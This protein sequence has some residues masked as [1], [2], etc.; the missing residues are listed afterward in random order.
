MSIIAFLLMALP[1]QTITFPPVGGGTNVEVVVV[2]WEEMGDDETETAV[3][4]PGY[5][6]CT[7][8][9]AGTIGA[10]TVAIQGSNDNT[11]WVQLEDTEGAAMS[12][13]ATGMKG[14]LQNPLWIRPVTS[15]GSSNDVDVILNCR[16]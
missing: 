12:F 8:Q 15:G 6:D 14:I 13:S 7:V 3:R 9:I 5:T 1:A 2:T 10:G 16:R 4:I 11:N